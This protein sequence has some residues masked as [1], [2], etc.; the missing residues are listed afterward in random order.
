MRCLTDKAPAT[1]PDAQPDVVTLATARLY[2]GFNLQHKEVRER[3]RHVCAAASH[4]FYINMRVC[5]EQE[6]RK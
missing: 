5:Q 2:H 4:S 3:V 1:Q 6:H